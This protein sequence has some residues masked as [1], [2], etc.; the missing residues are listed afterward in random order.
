MATA[1]WALSRTEVVSPNDGAITN[2]TV[3]HGRHG[4]RSTCRSSAS[5]MPMPGASWPT[6]SR[7]ISAPSRS[8]ARPGCGSTA[9][10]WHFHRARITGIARGFSREAGGDEAAALRGADHRLDPSAA[11]H[12]GD[13][14][15][16]RPA[17]GPASSTWAPTRAPSSSHEPQSGDRALR[18]GGRRGFRR[19][20]PHDRSDADQGCWTRTGRARRPIRRGRGMGLVAAVSVMLATT[21]GAAAAARVAVVGGDQRLHDA[22]V[23]GRGLDAAGPAAARRHD[24]RRRAWAS[25]WRAGCPTTISRSACSWPRAT[26]LGVV[27]MQV[28]PHGLAWLF[29]HD[30]LDPGAAG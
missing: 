22:D 5:S 17:A 16:G 2:L 4:Q 9:Q 28:S 14:R 18:P 29:V 20:R 27:A 15:A 7:T 12:P 8:A 19:G 1:Q 3:R 24:R 11:P 30:H 21:H 6:T 26:M 23:D 13:D 25:S 10:P